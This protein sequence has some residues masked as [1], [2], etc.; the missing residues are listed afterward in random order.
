MVGTIHI[1]PPEPIGWHRDRCAAVAALP[2][3]AA[4]KHLFGKR[5]EKKL[6]PAPVKTV[7]QKK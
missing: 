5:A 6:I 2:F 4:Q 3:G 7:E 1:L